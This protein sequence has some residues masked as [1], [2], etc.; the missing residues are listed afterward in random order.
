MHDILA[1]V[2]DQHQVPREVKATMKIY[3][4]KNASEKRKSVTLN[5]CASFYEECFR[6]FTLCV[7][8]LWAYD[9]RLI[10]VDYITSFSYVLRDLR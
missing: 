8:C 5:N 1:E 9:W 4:L 6:D 10:E 7:V 2:I 3:I